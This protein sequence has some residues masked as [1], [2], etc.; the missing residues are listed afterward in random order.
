MSQSDK[1]NQQN[2]KLGG[3]RARMTSDEGKT[4]GVRKG[5]TNRT[6]ATP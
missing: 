6:A 3:G 4:A 2:R 1:K 5:N